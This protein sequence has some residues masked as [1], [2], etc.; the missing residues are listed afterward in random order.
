ML[1]F[2]AES[3]S[4]EEVLAVTQPGHR[5]LGLVLDPHSAATNSRDA[6]VHFPLWYQAEKGGL[7]DFN[8]AG[9]WQM[10]VRYRADRAPTAFTRPT[11]AWLPPEEF[12]W[13]RDQA[14][15]Y[16]YFFVRRSAPLPQGYFPTGKCEPVLLETAGVWSVYENAKC[17]TDFR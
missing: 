4:F 6:Y 12:E 5:A 7:V 13:A 1:A 10:I 2:A 8:F 14:E 11:W 9:Y 15:I 3:A 16:R 17:L